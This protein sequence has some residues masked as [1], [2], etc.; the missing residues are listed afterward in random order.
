MA[1]EGSKAKVRYNRFVELDGELLNVLQACTLGVPA[2]GDQEQK[3]T[4]LKD[5]DGRWSVE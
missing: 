2:A 5:D 3:V 1:T 4:L